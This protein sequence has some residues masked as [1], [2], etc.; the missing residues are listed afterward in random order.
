MALVAAAALRLA[1]PGSRS[2]LGGLLSMPIRAASSAPVTSKGSRRA[3]DGARVRRYIPQDASKFVRANGRLVTSPENVDFFRQ[4]GIEPDNGA[5]SRF[6]GGPPLRAIVAKHRL[7][8]AFSRRHV[9]HPYDLPVFDPR[10]H[11]LAPMKRADY[12]RKTRE[13]PLWFIFT[14]A[15]AASPV[16]RTLTQRRL[17]RAAHE[18]LEAIGYALAPGM[19]PDKEIRGTLWVVM[20]DP[21]RA[22]TLSPPVFGAALAAALDSL[23]SRRRS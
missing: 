4:H 10:G 8:L 18:A 3:G 5:M 7:S 2:R 19:A 9:L 1:A 16:V 14:A 6:E 21:V 13:Q 22:A 23:C 15:G 17:A 12:V 20:H 11:P